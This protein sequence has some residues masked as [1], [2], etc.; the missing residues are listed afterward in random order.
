MFTRLHKFMLIMAGASLL[1]SACG[2]LDAEF[3]ASGVYG[4]NILIGKSSPNEGSIITEK[5]TIRPLF[6]SSVANDPDITGLMVFLQNENGEIVGRK[7]QYTLNAAD[8]GAVPVTGDDDSETG[9]AEGKNTKTLPEKKD[10]AAT[11]TLIYVSR[12]DK[13]LPLFPLPEN[14]SIGQYTLVFQVLGERQ[15]LDQISRPVYYIGG[16]EFTLEDIQSYAP[17]ISVSS[18]PVP[19]GLTIMLETQV[20]ADK[21][22]D[23]YIIWYN[24]KKRIH[25]GRIADGAGRFLWKTP[26]Q[27]GFQTLRAEA[28]PF[29]PAPDQTGKIKE[30][31]LPV[32]VKGEHT[33]VFAKEAE[34]FTNWYQFAGDLRDSKA[35]AETTRAL[36]TRKNHSNRWL[37]TEGIYGLAISTGDTYQ[38]PLASFI[39]SG[40]EQGEGRFLLRF[41]PV[42]GGTV[43]NAL[44]NGVGSSQAILDM[45]LSFGDKGLILDLKTGTKSVEIPIPLKSFANEA[46]IMVGIDFSIEADRFTAAVSLGES[47][48]ITPKSVSIILSNPLSGEGTFR[49]GGP[50]R[51]AEGESAL[52]A[53]E[54]ANS[55]NSA[56]VN[57]EPA[58]TAIFYEFAAK[59]HE[60]S[61]LVP[62]NAAAEASKPSLGPGESA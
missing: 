2:E 4:V 43:F 55:E 54:T 1:L 13:E 40:D 51:A 34:Q 59:T 30:L 49:L 42:S 48:A 22:L 11:D 25:E 61:P 16:A 6:T 14:L 3:P 37:P 45:N 19:P 50:R 56:T 7:V 36:V 35:P 38:V 33:G 27:P 18:H 5:D 31:S 23:P 32:S 53:N 47:N 41:K 44:F 28:F 8:T 21:R 9:A 20:T 12:L 17:G 46:F 10:I 15:V 62:E 60:V 39:R 52:G 58:V 29:K 57:G 26:D 24:G